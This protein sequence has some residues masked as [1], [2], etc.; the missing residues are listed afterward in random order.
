MS[1]SNST[2]VAIKMGLKIFKFVP[3]AS[4]AILVIAVNAIAQLGAVAPE[5]AT[6]AADKL[7]QSVAGCGSARSRF[8]VPKLFDF[9]NYRRV[10]HKSY[11]SFT[12]LLVRQKLFLAKALRALI[13]MINYKRGK[14]SY[15][16][17]LNRFSDFTKDELERMKNHLIGK[18][19]FD[20]AV[21]IESRLETLKKLRRS[22]SS[23]DLFFKPEDLDK[24]LKSLAK[25]YPNDRDVLELQAELAANKLR[26][27]RQADDELS[28]DDL[29]NTGEGEGT[30]PEALAEARDESE[31]KNPEYEKVDSPKSLESRRTLG[32]Q[33]SPINRVFIESRQKT[34]QRLIEQNLFD[35]LK[36]YRHHV[37]SL[38]RTDTNEDVVF[39]DHR[40]SNCFWKPRFQGLCQSCYAFA[41]AAIAE[42]AHCVQT[43]ELLAFSEQYMV[44]CGHF[45]GMNGCIGGTQNG[46]FNFAFNFGFELQDNYPY[47]G[48]KNS[49]PYE[50]EDNHID[51]H[52]T[53]YIRMNFNGSAVIPMDRW[54]E[55]IRIAPLFP[56]VSIVGDF[57][58]YG[59][60][61]WDS[62]GCTLG[63]HAVVLIG[64]GREDGQEYWILRNSHSVHW[65]EGGYM[66]IAKNSAC[67]NPPYAYSLGF[68]EGDRK[69]R[70]EK[71]QKYDAQR[72]GK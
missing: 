15:Y 32:E 42:Y 35:Q 67:I 58:E 19:L 40:K 45:T 31:F 23:R 46:V 7:P 70:L 28:V 71:N 57:M 16:L 69:F 65:G 50:K 43:G 41:L 63:N 52:Q 17:K 37:E 61:V 54:D 72:I 68:D 38:T 2:T 10:F 3:V 59:G 39:V 53:G 55:F 29:I 13:S 12:E 47:T 26:K 9:D 18:G 66:R 5:P 56:A 44:D 30:S 6:P 1:N 11:A 49:C 62:D 27:R 14:L 48:T 60:G 21:P 34:E 4:L 25:V 64:H 8:V 33:V 24:V 20:N 51:I 36:E 22:K